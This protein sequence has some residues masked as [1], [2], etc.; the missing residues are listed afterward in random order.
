MGRPRA[1]GGREVARE[2]E[3]A[4]SERGMRWKEEAREGRGGD[5][6]V[7][8]GGVGGSEM[9]A[10]ERMTGESSSE[11][12]RATRRMYKRKRGERWM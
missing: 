4:S 11:E 6:L 10:K 9:R 7:K 5:E 2:G 8:R 3:D 12:A 1:K